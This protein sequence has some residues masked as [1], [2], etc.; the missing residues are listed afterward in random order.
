MKG[1]AT[2]IAPRIR[3]RS[4]HPDN[5]HAIIFHAPKNYADQIKKQVAVITQLALVTGFFVKNKPAKRAKQP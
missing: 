2:F 3:R 1:R 4:S 5:L